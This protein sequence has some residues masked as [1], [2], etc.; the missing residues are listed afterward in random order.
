VPWAAVARGSPAADLLAP[1]VELTPT[2]VGCRGP[3]TDGSGAGFV[4]IDAHLL[5]PAIEATR[6]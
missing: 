4:D 1:T 6:R 3:P 5:V 2:G